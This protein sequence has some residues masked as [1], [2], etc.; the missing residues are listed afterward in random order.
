MLNTLVVVIKIVAYIAAMV[1]TAAAIL[2]H[3]VFLGVRVDDVVAG[4]VL[5]LRC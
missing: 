4:P 5:L 3:L 2:G 1:S